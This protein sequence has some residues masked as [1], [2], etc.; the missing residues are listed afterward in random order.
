[1]ITNKMRW[2]LTGW[3]GP[4]AALFCLVLAA[5][6]CAEYG[7]G[8]TDYQAILLSGGEDAQDFVD[9]RGTLDFG[10]TAE[11]RFSETKPL[12]GYLFDAHQGARVTITLTVDNGED[13]VLI[14]YGPVTAKGIWGEHIAFDDDGKDGLNSLLNDFTLP[15]SGLYLIGAA[16]YDGSSGGDFVLALGCRGECGEPSCPDVMCDLYCPND[17]MTDPN[18]CPICRCADVACVVDDDCPELDWT[19]LMPRCIDGE[20]VYEELRCDE[21]TQCPPGFECLALGPGGATVEH[22]LPLV[23]LSQKGH[24]FQQRRLAAAVVSQHGQNLAR[25][26]VQPRHVQRRDGSPGSRFPVAAHH[27]S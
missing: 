25:L 23:G 15:A 27:V 7:K 14:L 4:L 20:C 8:K 5:Q 1:M 26:D 9:L 2:T 19:D 16:T 21:D 24:S 3:T 10:Q 12:T 22:D 6:G 11:D 18:G 17:F 13:P